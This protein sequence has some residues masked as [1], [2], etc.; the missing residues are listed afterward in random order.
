MELNRRGSLLCY[1]EGI[2]EPFTYLYLSVGSPLRGGS[3]LIQIGS[4]GY[5]LEG[6][7]VPRRCLS[8]AALSVVDARSREVGN[9]S[10]H[11]AD[12]KVPMR[13]LNSN[14]ALSMRDKSGSD[15]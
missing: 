13:D 5:Y 11:P 7:R 12:L 9:L 1:P 8:G 6:V 15:G 2:R 3:A 4:L 14:A 10:Y